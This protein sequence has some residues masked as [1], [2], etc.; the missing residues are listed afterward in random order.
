MIQTPHVKQGPRRIHMVELVRD[1]LLRFA[2]TE[3]NGQRATLCSAELWNDSKRERPNGQHRVS[4][5][6]D[7]V[8]LTSPV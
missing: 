5:L 7:N 3:P 4:L 2:S 1:Y 6:H 8:L